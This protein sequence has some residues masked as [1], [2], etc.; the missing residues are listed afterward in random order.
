MIVGSDVSDG[1]FK[2]EV[3]RIDSPNGG[4]TIAGG[5]P[6]TISWSTNETLRPVDEDHTSPRA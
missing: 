3:V 4:E 5:E 2:T 1:F 6:T